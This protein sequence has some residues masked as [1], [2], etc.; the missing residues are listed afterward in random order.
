MGPSPRALSPKAGRFLHQKLSRE[1]CGSYQSAVPKGSQVW[2]DCSAVRR[3]LWVSSSV[4][5]HT[6]GASAHIY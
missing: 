6:P 5:R 2:P 4:R 1:S 3:S